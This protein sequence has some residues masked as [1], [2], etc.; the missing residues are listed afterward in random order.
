M[1][2]GLAQLTIIICLTDT[3]FAKVVS[4]GGRR[5]EDCSVGKI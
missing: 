4:F 5:R 1:E 3:I 2:S